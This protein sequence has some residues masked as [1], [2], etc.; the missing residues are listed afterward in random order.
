[1]RSEHLSE[2]INFDNESEVEKSVHPLIFSS[3]KVARN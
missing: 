3:V 2:V 1:M